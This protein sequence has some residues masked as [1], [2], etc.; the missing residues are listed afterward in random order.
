[1]ES[2]PAFCRNAH[3]APF[4]SYLKQ[5]SRRTQDGYLLA[6][7]NIC[8]FFGYPYSE[9]DPSSLTQE[10]YETFLQENK[11]KMSNTTLNFHSRVFDALSRV[12]DLPIEIEVLRETTTLTD[13]EV[14]ER[15]EAAR[16]SLGVVGYTC[17]V[18]GRDVEEYLNAD[19]YYETLSMDDMLKDPFLC[20]HEVVEVN[21]I[22][23]RGLRITRDVII[24]HYEEVME[25]HL[26]ATEVELEI[27]KEMG[28]YDNIRTKV[29]YMKGWMEDPLLTDELK[30]KC[31]DLYRKTL[32]LLE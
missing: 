25:A 8:D 10:H 1:M 5:Q 20:I 26:K 24:N 6:L 3:C 23:R 16:H 15:L 14:E 30:R 17:D 13:P 18:S 28:N 32:R 2:R 9:F 22:K 27:S 7:Q 12:Y 29:T 4:I 19:T 31:E 21:E 11:K